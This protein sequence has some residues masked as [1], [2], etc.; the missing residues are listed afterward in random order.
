MGNDIISTLTLTH[1]ISTKSKSSHGLVYSDVRPRDKQNFSSCQKICSEQI[2][3][4]VHDLMV[5]T[6]GGKGMV[7][8]LRLMQSVMTAYYERNIRLLDRLHHCWLSVF[9]C[10]LWWIWLN[11]QPRTQLQIK[12]NVVFDSL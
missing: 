2:I 12:Y 5:D 7:I 11:S 10:R 1:L 4:L 3:K 9:I 6:P 8:Y